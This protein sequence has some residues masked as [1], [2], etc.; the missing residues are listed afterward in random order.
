MKKLLFIPLVFLLCFTFSCQQ[1]EEAAEEPAV[2]IEVESEA[3]KEAFWVQANAVK[4]KD[5]ELLVSTW[6][7]D[8]ISSR[9]D[10]EATREWFANRF[11]QGRYSDNFSLDKIEIS[12]SA[13]LGYIAFSFEYFRVEEGKTTSTGKGFN[14][15]I[16]KKQADG[17][18]KQVAFE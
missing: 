7:D 6:T 13:D 3:M 5:V 14:V 16:W 18:W 2:D 8:L 10:R 11:A 4:A 1:G 15:G 12:A 9:G 17:T